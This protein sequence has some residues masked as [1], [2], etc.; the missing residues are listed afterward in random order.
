MSVLLPRLPGPSAESML[1]RLFDGD[2]L[3]WP[4]FDPTDLPDEARFASTGGS[5]A[6]GARPLQEIRDGI[7]S[8]AEEHG[9]GTRD[10]RATQAKFDAALGAWLVQQ[11]QLKTGEALRDDVWSFI[12][13]V[14]APDIVDWRFGK[15]RERYLGGVRNTFQRLW[16]RARVLD[17]GEEADNRWGLI[18]S[19]TEDAL[20]QITER[21]SIGAD[22][23]LSSELAEAWVRASNRLG[24]RQMEDVMRL[25]ILR[26]RIRNEI[27]SLSL[28]PQIELEALLDQIFD[29]AAE[30]LGAV[31]DAPLLDQGQEVTSSASRND[32]TEEPDSDDSSKRRRSW[33]FWRAR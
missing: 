9:F 14:M 7:L 6:A 15:S 3:Q 23:V 29:S 5:A 31:K 8:V 4:G 17:R 21:P 16:M 25:A 33:A 26:L 20:V 12:G 2:A 13:V 22:A 28:L 1:D 30:A 18:D 10:A 32:G 27:R 24:R 11:P 19:L